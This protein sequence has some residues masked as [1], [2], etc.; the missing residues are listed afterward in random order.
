MLSLVLR[1]ALLGA[2]VLVSCSSYGADDAPRPDAGPATGE[3]LGA[4][5]PNATCNAGLVCVDSIC[6]RPGEPTAGDGG[7]TDAAG[8]DSATPP[9][10]KA[11][12]CA[13]V[14]KICGEVPGDDCCATILVPGGT[15]KRSYDGTVAYQD[16]SYVATVS[17][18]HLDKY[19]VTVARM[20]WFVDNY[21]NDLPPKGSGKNPNDATDPGWEE[22]YKNAMPPDAATLRV[23]LACPDGTWTETPGANENK[24]ANCLTWYIAM[25]F[26]AADAGRL[27]TEAEWNYAAAGGSEQRVYPW[28]E[29]PS[30]T[31]VDTTRAVYSGLAIAY[32]GSK[33]AG[34]GR[35]GH[36]DLAGNVQE[37][38]S[39]F[40]VTP[41]AIVPCNDCTER[42]PSAEKVLRGGRSDYEAES[43]FASRRDGREAGHV[44]QG[45]GVRCAR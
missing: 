29:P 28:S 21:P 38:I 31:D 19:E 34:K 15:F 41:Y 33:P 7:G 25:A 17:G 14:G 18:F 37:W 43:L 23:T 20:R 6:L 35:W 45:G 42:M 2:I 9:P 10:A 5:Y 40:R 26:C 16:G 22:I 36:L 13:N 8:T 30:S 11:P 1:R 39:D 24:P 32:V 12:S 27:P 44:S 4:C 3:R